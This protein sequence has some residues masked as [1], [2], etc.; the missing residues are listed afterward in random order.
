MT[1]RWAPKPGAEAA[2]R[3]DRAA[4]PA[5]HRLPL[6]AIGG[7]ELFRL[8]LL[9]TAAAGT[10][11]GELAWM[12]EEQMRQIVR[13][14]VRE[15]LKPLLDALGVSLATRPQGAR[16]VKSRAVAPVE[17][18]RQL[19]KVSEVA[20]E[21]RAST[22]SVYE[23]IRRGE[24]VA[25]KLKGLGWRVERKALDTWMSRFSVCPAD[26][27]EA[28]RRDLHGKGRPGRFRLRD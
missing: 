26:E 7:A 16:A 3:P 20:R 28:L 8:E 9:G 1:L 22:Q 12:T 13:E 14:V 21:L 15:E 19:L 2:G 17:Q 10:G 11:S 18:G 4:S 24:L 6:E 27:L 25:S 5:G 23:A